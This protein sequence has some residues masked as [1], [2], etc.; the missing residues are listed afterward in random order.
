M[1]EKQNLVF[2]RKNENLGLRLREPPIQGQTVTSES[3]NG[4]SGLPQLPAVSLLLKSAQL[5]PSRS[6]L[7]NAGKIFRLAPASGRR[8]WRSIGGDL[9]IARQRKH[10]ILGCLGN[11][12][13]KMT[14][15]RIRLDLSE[16]L[17]TRQT[18]S[19][20]RHQRVNSLRHAN[21]NWTLLGTQNP[22]PRNTSANA[23]NL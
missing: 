8:R 10:V 16:A 2:P 11:K 14:R 5:E 17:G 19:R 20:E 23:K 3:T 21:R 7:G 22:A 4:P 9:H 1:P 15:L 18:R 13:A 6:S 12:H